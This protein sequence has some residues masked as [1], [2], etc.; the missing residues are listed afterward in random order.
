MT[1]K[2]MIAAPII[3][4]L[5]MLAAT[6]ATAAPHKAGQ[7]VHAEINQL[8]RKINRTPGISP[9]EEAR[10]EARLKSLR[11]LNRS[12]ARNG[13]SGRELRVLN[14][15]INSINVAINK[16]SRDNNRRVRR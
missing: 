2:L 5:G 7:S 8:D 10:L 13:Y 6:P 4:T 3:A 1:K 11:Q 16:Q 14:Q 15:Q 12:Y 9:R